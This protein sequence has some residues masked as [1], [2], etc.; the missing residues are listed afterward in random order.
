MGGSDHAKGPAPENTDYRGGYKSTEV[1]FKA[2]VK[3]VDMF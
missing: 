1:I 2:A 3:L